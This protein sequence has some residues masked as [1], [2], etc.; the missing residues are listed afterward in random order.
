MPVLPTIPTYK[1]FAVNKMP[2]ERHLHTVEV[3]VLVPAR[4]SGERLKTIEGRE[5]QCEDSDLRS[6]H[7][8]PGSSTELRQIVLGCRLS[9]CHEAGV[10]LRNGSS[11]ELRENSWR[12]HSKACDGIVNVT[13]CL[14]ARPSQ[15]GLSRMSCARGCVPVQ[16]QVVALGY[17]PTLRPTPGEIMS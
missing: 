3:R 13:F 16:V 15:R 1:P 17:T 14:L 9:L 10:S 11:R 7:P 8:R 5:L 6:A 12:V 2:V 4:G